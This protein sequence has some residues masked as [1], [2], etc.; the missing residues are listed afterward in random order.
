MANFKVESVSYDER[1]KNTLIRVSGIWN[2]S[3]AYAYFKHTLGHDQFSI[4]R[5]KDMTGQ[6]KYLIVDTEDSY[7]NCFSFSI[8]DGD[9]LHNSH[10]AQSVQKHIQV[11]RRWVA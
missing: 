7:S 9:I 4:Y 11:I 3:Q 8:I 1:H 5:S 10:P 2:L 6:P